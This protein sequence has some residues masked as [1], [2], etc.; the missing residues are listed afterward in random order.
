MPAGATLDV[1]AAPG[2][3]LR[4][5]V[6]VAG[7]DRR[8]RPPGS[9]ATFTL[10]RFGGHGGRAL[11][12]GRRAADRAAA[13]AAPGRVDPVPAERPPRSSSDWEIG[14]TEGPHAA[15]DFFTREDM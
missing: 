15:P 12:A 10:G 3:G 8:A 14:V 5:Y 13:V 6:C 1:G 11:R 7:G 2:P 4:T 9:A